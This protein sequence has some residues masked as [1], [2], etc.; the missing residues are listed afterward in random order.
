MTKRTPVVKE[1]KDRYA[2]LNNLT[3][4]R[5]KEGIS[6]K[7]K[8]QGNHTKEADRQGKGPEEGILFELSTHYT[9]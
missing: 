4:G 8:K 7:R 6:T 5:A 2:T 3:P 9:Y 1:L